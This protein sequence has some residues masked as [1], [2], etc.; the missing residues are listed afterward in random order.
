MGGCMFECVE[1][2]GWVFEWV[3]GWT[4]GR[5]GRMGGRVEGSGEGRGEGRGVWRPCTVLYS[6]FSFDCFVFSVSLPLDL[7][8]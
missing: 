2:D 5:V 8:I 1:I 4:G 3:D 6:S 7:W